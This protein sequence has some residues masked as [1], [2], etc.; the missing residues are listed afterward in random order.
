VKNSEFNV[1]KSGPEVVGWRRGRHDGLRG[2]QWSSQR[3]SHMWVCL[4]YIFHVG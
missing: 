1:V 3:R 4:E 2:K